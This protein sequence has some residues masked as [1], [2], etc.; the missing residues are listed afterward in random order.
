V[1]LPQQTSPP[2]DV[3]SSRHIVLEYGADRRTAIN[4]QPVELS[5]LGRELRRI[6]ATRHEKTM[7][8]AGDG[9]LRYGEIVAVIDVAKGAGVQRV[10]IV[11]E[12][13]RAGR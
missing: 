7:F 5:S 8:I 3:D 1:G 11:T 6:F 2:G 4:H 10:G 9:S 13:M 12:A